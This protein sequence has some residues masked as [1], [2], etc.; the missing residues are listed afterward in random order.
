M[1]PDLVSAPSA[2]AWCNRLSPET[3]YNIMGVV[4]VCS[5]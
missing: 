2:P 3:D 1:R 4:S 5:S